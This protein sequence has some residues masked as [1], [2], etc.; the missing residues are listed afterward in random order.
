MSLCTLCQNLTACSIC[1]SGYNL[2]S[3]LTCVHCYV[4]GCAYCSSTNS[5]VCAICNN[6]LGYY[7]DSATQKCKT[8]C[9]DGILV[10]ATEACD[11]NNTLSYDG[12]SS[13]CTV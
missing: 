6:S 1:N 5:N 8:Q 13:T 10:S 11:D 12:C 7:N 4:T 3:I 9:G 2:S